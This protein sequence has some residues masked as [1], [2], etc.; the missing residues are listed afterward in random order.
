MRL[1]LDTNVL[2]W[3]LGDD[4][5]LSDKAKAAY[6]DGENEVIVSIASA[7]EIFIKIGTGKLQI[8]SKDPARFLRAQLRENGI[9]LLGIKYE[10]VARLLSLP[11][12]HKDPFDRLIIAQALHEGLPVLSSD[13]IFAAYNVVNLY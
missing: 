2:L 7:W 3:I 6:L 5:R 1:L 8:G 13:P 11:D 4:P 10:H 12:I 9:G